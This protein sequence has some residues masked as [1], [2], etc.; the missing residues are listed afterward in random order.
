M[1]LTLD[2]TQPALSVLL[3]V[4]NYNNN[5]AVTPDQISVQQVAAL[6]S[7]DSSGMNTIA[8]I[9]STPGATAFEGREGFKYD[10]T[11]ISTVPGT[12]STTFSVGSA[13][14]LSD[15]LTQIN[16]AWSLNLTVS[17]IEDGILPAIPDGTLSVSLMM[18][19]T[20]GSLLW[21]NEVEISITP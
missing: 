18:K 9:S 17:D 5:T 2:F 10:R 15:L 13:I 6:P 12:R 7:T 19:M 16:A 3:A 1:S 20:P 4:I 8:F 21:L 11:D 14:Y